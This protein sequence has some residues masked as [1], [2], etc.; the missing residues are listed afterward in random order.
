MVDSEP[1][2]S[3]VYSPLGQEYTEATPSDFLPFM[4][5]ETNVTEPHTD[6][7]GT[8]VSI[9]VPMIDSDTGNV[10]AVF[11]VDYPAEDWNNHACSTNIKGG[12]Y[13]LLFVFNFAVFL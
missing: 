2:D 11:G 9:L 5:K 3:E 7:W 8:W 4:N 10:I 13:F 12:D 1:V 6:S